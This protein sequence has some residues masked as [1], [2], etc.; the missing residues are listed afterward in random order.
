M[1]VRTSRHVLI[2]NIGVELLPRECVGLPRHCQ[3]IG[4]H[5]PKR[6]EQ[7]GDLVVALALGQ[8]DIE[9]AGRDV[10]RTREHRVTGDEVFADG[11][12]VMQ[13]DTAPV[14]IAP[15]A[16]KRSARWNKRDNCQRDRSA[17]LQT[18]GCEHR[19]FDRTGD[20]EDIFLSHIGEFYDQKMSIAMDL[21]DAAAEHT[22]NFRDI[23]K[24]DI[25]E[26]PRIVVYRRR[27]Q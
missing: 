18:D 12:T 22:N 25:R 17:K 1:T 7:F 20:D 19:P 5:R 14:R 21:Y 26:D 8:F 3:Q 13:R 11:R 15:V 9:F 23:E 4:L 2:E 16:P 6:R 24:E 27:N 10:V